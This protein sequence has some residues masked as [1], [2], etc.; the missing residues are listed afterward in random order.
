VD[1]SVGG[2]TGINH[3]HVKN[4]IGAFYHPQA[5]LINVHLLKTLPA[6]EFIAG[7]AEVI[8]Y[9]LIAD[10]D[11]FT[12]LETNL[13]LILARDEQTLLYMIT[14]CV[15]LK[16]HIVSQDAQEK[17]GLRSLLNFGHTFGHALE[18][19]TDY[20]Q[21]LHGEA[22]AIGMVLAA[23]LSKEHAGLNEESVKRIETLLRQAGL[24]NDQIKL[25]SAANLMAL[26]AADK[27]MLNN[28]WRFVLLKNIGSAMLVTDVSMSTVTDILDHF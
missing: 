21:F 18:A 19:C 27:K 23:R 13:P 16:A 2:K 3:Q 26:M 6:R 24:L 11:F 12:W 28:Q 22:V 14:R 8:K 25:P 5:V 1:S 15:T 10:A 17:N 7:L 20:Q 9:G 4:A